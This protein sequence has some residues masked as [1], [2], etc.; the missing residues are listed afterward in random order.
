M[1]KI[2]ETIVFF[3]SGPVAAKSLELLLLWCDVEAVV[4][5]PQ[6]PHHRELFPVIDIAQKYELP[7]FTASN[8]QELD[9]LIGQSAFKSRIGVLVDYGIIVSQKVIDSFDLGIVNS[10]FSILPEWRGADP[11]TFAVLSGQQQT[12]VSLMLLVPRM[13]EGPL[14][15]YS[16]YD[17]LPTIT[18][19]ELTDDL[20]EIS[21][22]LLERTLPRYLAG[23][24]EPQ[25]QTVTK[26]QA[27]YSRKIAKEDGILDWRKTAEELE[28]EVRAFAGWPKS[29]TELAGKT[30]VI[31]KA[32]VVETACKPGQLIIKDKTLTL[33][34]KHNGLGI[35]ML[36]PAGKKEM[37]VLAFLA[38]YGATLEQD[39]D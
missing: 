13:D 9:E 8:R 38:G 37:P 26:R 33:G 27:S 25:P 6:P 14:I 18:T 32:H 3:G 30:I 5:K 10:H 35:D 28:R 15:A 39:R 1:K 7:L 22:A 16:E 11:I 29:R 20:I 21:N 23:T 4:T 34:T 36:I 19:P 2:S 24:I 12:G 31:T 17:L